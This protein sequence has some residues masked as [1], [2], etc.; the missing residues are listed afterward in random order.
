MPQTA[1]RNKIYTLIITCDLKR[2]CVPVQV[3]VYEWHPTTIIHVH[4]HLTVITTHN[5]HPFNHHIPQPFHPTPAI[6]HCTF[7]WERWGD[8]ITSS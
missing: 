1:L 4:V 2:M 8:L 7:S 6:I 3:K 5:Y